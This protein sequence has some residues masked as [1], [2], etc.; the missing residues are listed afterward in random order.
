MINQYFL[1]SGLGMMLAGILPVLWWRYRTLVPW[2]DFWLG[3]A[4]WG[5]AIFIK[6][7]L[8]L[9]ITPFFVNWLQGI[10]TILGI[11]ILSG[12][13]VGLRTGL[14][15][16]GFTYLLALKTRVKKY[17]F[18]QAV[19][20]GLGF[21]CAEAFLLGLFSFLSVSVLIVF[22]QLIDLMPPA[23]KVA[24]L[25]QITGP[26]IIAFAPIIERV[27]TILVHVFCTVL[28]IHA[29]R[30][31]RIE[32]F[33]LSF[34]VK[35]GFD[36]ALPL[37]MLSYD[38]TTVEGI[39]SIEAFVVLIGIVS[40]GGIFWLRS[41]YQKHVR[42]G[43]ISRSG[44]KG[45]GWKKGLFLFSFSVAAILILAIIYA[46]PNIASK[47]ER[48]PVNFDEFGGKYDFIMNGSYLGYSEFEVI[49]ARQYNGI[50]VHEIYEKTNFSSGGYDMSIEGVLYVTFDARPVF[51]NM[52]IRK[53]G[54]VKNILCEFGE[55]G[56][57][58]KV[59][60]GNVTR[61]NAI[62]ADPD[63]FIIANNIISHWAL[64][65]KAVKYEPQTTYIARI[66]SPN[67]ETVITRSFTVT[68]VET[69]KIKGR[70]YEAYVF[71][72]YGGNRNYISCNGLLLKIENPVIE[73]TL[74][75]DDNSNLD[76]CKGFFR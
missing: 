26:T 31:R 55:G 59:T 28:A 4:V 25:E 7:I 3:A 60:E 8:D 15:E 34:L 24:I 5:L 65:F 22:P 52:T 71:E 51:H 61:E 70:N 48:R 21:G 16:S 38:S 57:V 19:A 39:Y 56:V 36:G 40:L 69:V 1:L 9:T 18:Q 53:N 47:L 66:Y 11:A 27:F 2:R 6:V 29:V 76:R 62:T 63:I 67:L 72:E 35:T 17:D 41:V 44:R 43:R 10:Y 54:D 33:L 30:S 68:S 42:G 13:Y 50:D 23:Q 14:L 75:N 49:G 74:N 58:Q 73:I 20:F 32:Y 37:L 64:M 45:T 46:Q 12:A